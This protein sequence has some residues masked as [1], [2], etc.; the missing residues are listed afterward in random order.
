MTNFPVSADAAKLQD[1]I[2]ERAQ[3]IINNAGSKI[4]RP[5]RAELKRDLDRLDGV[6][7]AYAYLTDQRFK[8]PAGPAN[9]VRLE[10][11]E[12][13]AELV[14]AAHEAVSKLY[15]PRY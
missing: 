15:A 8:I 1:A 7:H 14:K 12:H 11:G 9:F 3:E 10:L 5:P 4:A 6:I 2:R 13:T